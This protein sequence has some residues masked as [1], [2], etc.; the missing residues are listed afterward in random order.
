MKVKKKYRPNKSFPPKVN[1]EKHHDKRYAFNF[2]YITRDDEYC[3]S[4]DNKYLTNK[5]RA[6]FIERICKLSEQDVV[7]LCFTG[8]KQGIEKIKES[9]VSLNILPEF[10]SSGRY[11]ECESDFRVFRLSTK[12]RVIGKVNDNIFYIM[13]VDARFD[14]YKH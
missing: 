2:S 9:S 8:K 1:I 11:D 12:G 10:K 6:K 7:S 4:K 5:V 13:G 14:S 3:L